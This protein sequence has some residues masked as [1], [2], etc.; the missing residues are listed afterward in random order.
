MSMRCCLMVTLVAM[1]IICLSGCSAGSEPEKPVDV[2]TLKQRLVRL[3]Y[4]DLARYAEEWKGTAVRYQGK[5]LQL[6]GDTA[7][8]V[9]ITRG[10]YGLWDDTVYLDLKGQ[11]KNARLLEGDII[12]FVGITNGTR[13]YLTVLGNEV[14]V[15]CITTYE[16][17]LLY[18]T[19]Q[20][21]RQITQSEAEA[22]VMDSSYQ[23]ERLEQYG[24]WWK[25]FSGLELNRIMVS[26]TKSSFPDGVQRW[27]VTTRN[28]EGD[29]DVRT[30]YVISS[31]LVD[32][33]FGE[34]FIYSNA[35]GTLIPVN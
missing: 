29:P 28:P 30:Q 21:L 20:K 7:L 23:T 15:P 3:P 19:G 35:E 13:T 2:A 11:S 14:T 17:G 34:M 31:I 9:D 16:I 10:A 32:E 6:I 27:Q 33:C 25:E 26:A 4:D 18:K 1:V 5:V 12:E 22:M 24:D 8:R